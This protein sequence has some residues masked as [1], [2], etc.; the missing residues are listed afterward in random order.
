VR[1]PQKRKV[2]V[3]KNRKSDYKADL[4]GEL[5][6]ADYAAGYVSAADAESRKTFLLAL[7]DVAEARGGMAKVP[8]AEL[9]GLME[10]VHLLRSPENARLLLAALRRAKR[11]KGKAETASKLRREMGLDRLTRRLLTD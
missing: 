3:V 7:R 5:K 11:G 1:R 10:T 4:L 9:G 6:D 8:A 2:T